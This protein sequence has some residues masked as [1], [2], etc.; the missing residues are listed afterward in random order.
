MMCEFCGLEIERWED[1]KIMPDGKVLHS[2]CADALKI[3]EM[4]DKVTSFKKV[5]RP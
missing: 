2:Y 1:E 4:I 3:K 5:K